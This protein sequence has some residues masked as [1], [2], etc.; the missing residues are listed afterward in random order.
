[1]TCAPQL[2]TRANAMTSTE[3]RPIDSDPPAKY[4]C[5]DCNERARTQKYACALPRRRSGELIRREADGQVQ[6]DTSRVS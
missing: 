2:N 1:M 3:P 5:E 4:A 6:A